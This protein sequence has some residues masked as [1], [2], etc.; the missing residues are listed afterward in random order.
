MSDRDVL[1]D[2]FELARPRMQSVAY[3]MLGSVSE[4]EDAVQEAWLRLD[5]SDAAAIEDVRIWLTTVVGRICLD[6]LRARKAR[7]EDFAGTWLP[8]PLVQEPVEDG[9]EHQAEL[10]DSI[11][12][13]LLIVLENLGPSERLAFVLHD[14]FALPFDEIGRIIER[15]T[16]AARQLASRA[17]RRVH[18][19]PQ[20]DR[21]VALQRQVVD[22][23]LSAARGGNFDALLNV[24]APDVVLRFDLGRDLAQNALVG[25]ESVARHVL[26]TAPRF[27][28]FANPVLVN[29]CAG[30]MFGPKD[31]PISVLGFTVVG[32]RIAAL[33]LIVDPA[34]LR[35]LSIGS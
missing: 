25:A 32:G 2:Q 7:R 9:P 11:G 4:A 1:A 12:L 29:G 5:R 18:A 27:I 21:D 8:E 31:H 14:I 24:L 28:E 30:A 19:A 17:R 6:K 13:A 34:K 16:E 33:D 26:A 20:P 10:A 22:A 3:S 15:S 35:H 23:F